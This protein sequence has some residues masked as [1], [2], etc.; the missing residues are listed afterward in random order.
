MPQAGLMTPVGPLSVTEENGQI[1]SVGW[2]PAGPATSA[3]LEVA[4]D[5]IAAYFAGQRQEFDLPLAPAT[6]FAAA[7]RAAMLAIPFGETRTYGDL[8]RALNVSPQAVGQGCGANPLP[9]IVPCHR[10]LGATGLGGYSGRGGA[11]TKVAL[12]RHEGAG[13][14]LL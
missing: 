11:E 9:L 2:W 1:T 5:Q 3:L 6:G 14:F 4:L 13:G 10:V 8:A 7:M 12:L